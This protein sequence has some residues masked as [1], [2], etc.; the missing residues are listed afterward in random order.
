MRYRQNTKG[1]ILYG[2]PVNKK[3]NKQLLEKTQT[4]VKHRIHFDDEDNLVRISKV[5]VPQ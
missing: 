4:K 3:K 1:A 2:P 5:P